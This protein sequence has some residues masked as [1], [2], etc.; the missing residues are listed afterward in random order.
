M[1]RKAIADGCE[2]IIV[3]ADESTYETAGVRSNNWAKFKNVNLGG[4]DI[5]DTIDL[6][7][8]G[9]YYGK[10]LRTGLFGSYLMAAY[11]MQTGRFES[12]CK[13]GSGFSQAQ[14]Q[15]LHQRVKVLH[16]DDVQSQRIAADLYSISSSL[17]PDV[18][19]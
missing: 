15:E 7:P 1:Q 2:G 8:V 16:E 6:V 9:G 13:L 10:G 18:W 14:L 4:G 19:L 11:N 3:K 5:R 17:K 12:V